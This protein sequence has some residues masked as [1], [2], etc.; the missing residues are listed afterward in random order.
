MPLWVAAGPAAG[1]RRLGLF[2]HS[3]SVEEARERWAPVLGALAKLGWREGERL[4]LVIRVS[5]R[6]A[7]GQPNPYD[8][9]PQVAAEL[10]AMRP[11]CIM[12]RGTPITRVLAQATR[13]IPIVTG[14]ADLVASG[15]VKSLAR[16]G[17][18][19]TGL[20]DGATDLAV[21]SVE[22]LKA[23]VPGLRQVAIFH[24]RERSF[25]EIGDFIESGAKASG[26][27]AIRMPMVPP[28]DRILGALAG[29]REQ[30][31]AGGHLRVRHHAEAPCRSRARRHPRTP[32]DVDR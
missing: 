32:A 29:L 15:F 31:G 2:A 24:Y 26:V 6:Y 23:L 28:A 1:R 11:D 8:L 4:E 10:V 7:P 21:K 5:G 12:T 14:T 19:V 17:T 30:G 22:L 9:L 20:S 16:P 27:S 3:G 13:E 18:N 25:A